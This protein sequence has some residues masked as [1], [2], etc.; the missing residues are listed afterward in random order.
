MRMDDAQLLELARCL[1]SL[2][3]E[4][5]VV[6]MVDLETVCPALWELVLRRRRDVPVA[7]RPVEGPGV[8]FGRVTRP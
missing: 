7:T 1:E 4:G 5:K 2:K 8:Y 6:S 3:S